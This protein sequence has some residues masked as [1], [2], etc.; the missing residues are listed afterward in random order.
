MTTLL[1]KADNGYR[2]QTVNG[3]D[4]I[5]VYYANGISIGGIQLEKY[6]GVSVPKF[7]TIVPQYAH[8]VIIGA[9]QTLRDGNYTCLAHEVMHV[10]LNRPGHYTYYPFSIYSPLDRVNLLVRGTA[11]SLTKE[12]GVTDSRRITAEQASTM[13]TAVPALLE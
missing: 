12:R 2:T 5:E 7:S 1:K 11:L 10:L 13:K 3:K 4:D 9:Q 8:S 6:W